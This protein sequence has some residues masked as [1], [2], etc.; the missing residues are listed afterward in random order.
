MAISC[1]EAYIDVTDI[2]QDDYT[3]L[4]LASSI[5]YD[6]ESKT[7]CTCSAGIGK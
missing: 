3:I 2:L 6:I 7:G 4:D 5:R 1:D